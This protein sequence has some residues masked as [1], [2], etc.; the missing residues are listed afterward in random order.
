MK[1][2]DYGKWTLVVGYNRKSGKTQKFWM[3][4]HS[5]LSYWKTFWLFS[6]INVVGQ[7]PAF[8]DGGV[9]LDKNPLKPLIG[10]CLLLTLFSPVVATYAITDITSYFFKKVLK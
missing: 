5:I 7:Y 9:R 6:K 8:Y 2:Q 3:P 10:L 4:G 1:I